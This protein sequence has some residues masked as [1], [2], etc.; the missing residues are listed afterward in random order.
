MEGR[1]ER[2]K[3]LTREAIAKTALQLFA[4]RGYDA[5]TVADV[6]AAADVAVT[7]VFNYFKTKEELFFGAFTPPT[8]ILAER[9]RTRP[10]LRGPVDVTRDL[11]LEAL[12]DMGDWAEAEHH[13]RIRAT[14]ANSPALQVQAAHRFRARRLESLDEVAAALTE[15]AAPDAFAHMM[16][17]QLLGLVDGTLRE[18]ERRTRAGQPPAAFAD[19]LREAL[20]RA[21]GA[22]SRAFEDYGRRLPN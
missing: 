11:L 3:R 16:A 20:E 4:E 10:P 21:C 17:T 19:E 22:L 13:N 6:A 5:V 8:N 18:A 12:E 9:L 7:T 14:L 2:K 1:R 15:P